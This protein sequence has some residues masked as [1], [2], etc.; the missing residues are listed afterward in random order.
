MALRALFA[1][2]LGLGLFW[3][4]LSLGLGSDPKMTCPDDMSVYVDPFVEEYFAPEL[5]D[6][7]Y[8]ELAYH[9]YTQPPPPLCGCQRSVKAASE[10]GLSISDAFSIKCKG[11][12]YKAPL[13]FNVSDTNGVLWG[14]CEWLPGG[15]CPDAVVDV[16]T[17]ECA[18]HPKTGNIIFA[19]INFYSREATPEAFEAMLASAGKHGLGPWM[20]PLTRLDHSEC[21][22]PE[23]D[24]EAWAP[25]A[26]PSAEA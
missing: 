16:G 9:D 23:G 4:G 7:T 8:Y 5:M 20:D 13:F 3:L 25:E 22:Y 11:K 24:A 17:R 26:G 21:T 2:E 10:D 6:G 18:N 15:V 1:L 12:D 14:K 19:G